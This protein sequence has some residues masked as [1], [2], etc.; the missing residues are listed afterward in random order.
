V[1][2]YMDNRS[3]TTQI[4]FTANKPDELW[5]CFCVEPH[6]NSAMGSDSDNHPTFHSHCA[7]HELVSIRY[8]DVCGLRLRAIIVSEP[9]SGDRWW[10]VNER[11]SV[12]IVI[13]QSHSRRQFCHVVI[14]MRKG[15]GPSHGEVCHVKYAERFRIHVDEENQRVVKA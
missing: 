11:P 10:L 4:Y 12:R 7:S 8:L 15:R 6:P 13:I 5:R 14:V 1:F 9:P 2:S 3:T